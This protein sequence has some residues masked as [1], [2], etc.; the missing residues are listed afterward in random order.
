[1]RMPGVAPLDRCIRVT[2]GTAEERALFAQVFEGVV[3]RTG[4]RRMKID[5]ACYCG[6][7]AFEA[8]INPENVAIC[9][10]TDCQTMSG[11]PFRHIVPA[12][13]QNF[14]LASGTPKTFVKTAESGNRRVMAFCAT[15]GTQLWACDEGDDPGRDLHPRRHGSTARAARPEAPSLVPLRAAV[16]GGHRR[17]AARGETAGIDSGAGSTSW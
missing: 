4:E 12:S 6:E 11:T 3:N 13:A 8:D 14:R 9:H 16:A 7:I 10:C 17:A 5:G 2:V 1:M 15:C